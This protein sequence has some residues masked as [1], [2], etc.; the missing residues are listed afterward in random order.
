MALIQC[1]E[2]K[3][4]ISDKAATCPRC[5]IHREHSETL[6]KTF[7]VFNESPVA[8]ATEEILIGRYG[9]VAGSSLGKVVLLTSKRLVFLDDSSAETHPLDHVHSIRIESGRNWAAVIFL[10]VCAIVMAA[11]SLIVFLATSSVSTNP[12][13][14]A[15]A[16]G[17]NFLWL[18]NVLSGS[19]AAA[20]LLS[21]AATYWAYRGYTRLAIS[22]ASGP[23]NYAVHAVDPALMDFVTK[24]EHAL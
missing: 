21:A 9:F 23:K 20:A 24:V 15:L 2:C 16:G 13:F 1:P 12:L 17:A 14:P 10:G 7:P 19:A 18:G 3:S 4:E 5:G 8:L 6:N 11:V 22:L